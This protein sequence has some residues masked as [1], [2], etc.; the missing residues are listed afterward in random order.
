ME[1]YRTTNDLNLRPNPNANPPSL[2]VFKR[3]TVVEGIGINPEG[4]WLHVHI[5]KTGGG[6]FEGWMSLKY[7]TRLAAPPQKWRLGVNLREFAYYGSGATH[8]QGTQMSQQGQQLTACKQN[9][10]KLVRFFACHHEFK[11]EDSINYIRKALDL[12]WN[13][14]EHMQAVICLDDSLNGSDTYMAGSDKYHAGDMG[15]LTVDYWRKAAYMNPYIPN[16]R[17]IVTAFKDHPAVAM[18]ELGN[19]FGLYPQVPAPQSSDADNFY[20]FVKVA[21]QEIRNLAPVNQLISIGL[22]TTH[23]VYVPTPALDRYAA[24]R[25]LYELPT[26]DVVGVHYYKDKQSE[27]ASFIDIDR[28]VA[29]DLGKPFYVGEMGALRTENDRPAYYEG[30]VRRWKDDD[31]L[32]VMPWQLDSF[33]QWNTGICDDYC[34][35]KWRDADYQS[36]LDKLKLLA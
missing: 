15:H 33:P 17:K 6:V 1:L 13:D 27:L 19:E 23:A 18:W 3:G 30:E 20:K 14:F 28:Q 25:R 4:T 34:I 7:L 21:S 8:I 24:S 12:L 22:I 35:G 26:V 11:I 2:G 16:L 10:I 5:P 9:G 29:R 32:T 36:I 31:A